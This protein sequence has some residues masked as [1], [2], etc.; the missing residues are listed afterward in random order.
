MSV[1]ENPVSAAEHKSKPVGTEATSNRKKTIDSGV[2]VDGRCASSVCTTV[3]DGTCGIRKW[4]I[5]NP[6]TA[7]RSA[8]NTQ[9]AEDRRRFCGGKDTG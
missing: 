8:Q 7:K 3:S 4:P 1:P 6:K 2:S 5:P 9:P